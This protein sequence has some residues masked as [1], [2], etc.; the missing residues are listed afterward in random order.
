MALPGDAVIIASPDHWHVRMAVDA[1][2]VL[3]LLRSGCPVD[4]SRVP[5]YGRPA[6]HVGVAPNRHR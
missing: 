5:G 1:L 4:D 2:D 6:G 3:H